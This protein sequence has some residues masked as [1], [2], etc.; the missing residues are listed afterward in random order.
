MDDQNNSELINSEGLSGKEM[1][2]LTALPREEL[3][4]D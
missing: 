3:G 2:L 4:N 1:V